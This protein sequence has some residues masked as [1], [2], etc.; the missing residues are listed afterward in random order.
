M[1][2]LYLKKAVAKNYVYVILHITSSEIRKEIASNKYCIIEKETFGTH[3]KGLRN[4]KCR[5]LNKNSKEDL[6]Y[7]RDIPPKK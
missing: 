5:H 2:E 3:T 7:R 1:C 4:L 6:E